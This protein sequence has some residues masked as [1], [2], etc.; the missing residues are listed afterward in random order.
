MTAILAEECK[1]ADE[2]HVSRQA[3]YLATK[4]PSQVGFGVVRCRFDIH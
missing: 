2:A 3:G 4:I 1:Q